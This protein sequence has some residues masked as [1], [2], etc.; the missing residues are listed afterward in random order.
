MD[1]TTT[2]SPPV[3]PGNINPMPQVV[4]HEKTMARALVLLAALAKQQVPQRQLAGARALANGHP[5]LV[6]TIRVIPTGS[7]LARVHG[8]VISDEQLP[9]DRHD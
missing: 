9:T 5:Q 7:T 1:R 3:I 4:R 8:E 2:T 6:R